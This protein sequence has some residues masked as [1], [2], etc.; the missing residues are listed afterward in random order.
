MLV[1]QTR[2]L[3][4]RHPMTYRNGVVCSERKFVWIGNRAFYVDSI[5]RIRPVENKN[6]KFNFCCFF[7]YV[8]QRRDVGVKTRAH[9][10]NVVDQRIESF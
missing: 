8:T 3:P 5:D 7:D 6:R 2:E 10:L 4:G 9:I 1:V